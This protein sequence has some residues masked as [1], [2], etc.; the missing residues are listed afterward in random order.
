MLTPVVEQR[1]EPEATRTDELFESSL[2]FSDT[3]RGNEW[4]WNDHSDYFN[5]N[6]DDVSDSLRYLLEILGMSDDD[7][8]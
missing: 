4:K 3:Q 1:E 5:D 7:N 8:K 2:T 6:E